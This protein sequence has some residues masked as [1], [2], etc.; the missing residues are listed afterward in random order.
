MWRSYGEGRNRALLRLWTGRLSC[1]KASPA[2]ARNPLAVPISVQ[3]I[4]HGLSIYVSPISAARN[5]LLMARIPGAHGGHPRVQIAAEADIE[6]L[7]LSF[8]DK[9][10]V[11]Q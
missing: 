5:L 2:T 4:P 10:V 11:R 8:F 1:K 7:Y 3:L 6:R 9:V